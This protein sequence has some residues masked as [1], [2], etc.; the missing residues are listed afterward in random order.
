MLQSFF[1]WYS[2]TFSNC[3]ISSNRWSAKI[4]RETHDVTGLTKT[5]ELYKKLCSMFDPKHNR[6]EKRGLASFSREIVFL[7]FFV[8]LLT[9]MNSAKMSVSQSISCRSHKKLCFTT[10][11]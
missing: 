9:I 3:E 1:T 8:A 5:K 6:S 4:D 7:K 11:V 2:S 10:V